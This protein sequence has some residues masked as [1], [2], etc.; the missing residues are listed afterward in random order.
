M[1]KRKNDVNVEEEN[2]LEI[3]YQK[4]SFARRVLSALLD[5]ILIYK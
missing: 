2:V 1:A 5:M 4:A 3:E